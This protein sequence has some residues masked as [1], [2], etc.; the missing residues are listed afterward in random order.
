M[1]A[2]SMGGT[3]AFAVGLNANA[4]RVTERQ[5]RRA[6]VAPTVVMK[7]APK[8]HDVRLPANVPGD[9]FVDS[10]CINCDTC[11]WWAP[12]TF[13]HADGQS[14]VHRQPETAEERKL[15]F[16]AL[17]A[18]P[19]APIHGARAPDEL[20]AARRGI[21][22]PTDVTGVF[23]NGYADEASFGACSYS[24]Q[25]DGNVIMVDSP[26]FSPGLAAN[27]E[28]LVRPGGQVKYLF[29]SHRDDV[30]QHARWAKHFG[31]R[32]IIHETEI[33]AR[34]GTDEC[35]VVL[36][37]EGPWSLED[38]RFTIHWVP[39]HTEGCVSLY[40]PL[41]KVLFTGDHLAWSRREQTLA[42][43]RHVCQMDWSRQMHSME[44]VR[45]LDVE[46]ILPGHG[47]KFRFASEADKHRELDKLLVRMEQQ[48]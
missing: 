8:R 28:S 10:T 17:L 9:F 40:D 45:A 23:H 26:R 20:Q 37:G 46:W 48:K 2:N 35:E 29:L 22:M 24:L 4:A 47:R 13:D 25:Y 1:N 3:M 14:Y 43:F 38:G 32:R 27:I 11:R 31:L 34:Q 16:Q 42:G 7:A 36:R 33:R 5:S 19:T 44:V 21:P 6:R 39:G 41:R 12:K 18:C 15:A 30:G